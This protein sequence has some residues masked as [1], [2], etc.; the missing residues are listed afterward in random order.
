MNT[1]KKIVLTAV[2]TAVVT[3]VVSCYLTSFI[4]DNILVYLPSLN[5]D[6]NFS[7]KIKAVENMLEKKYLYDFDNQTLRENAIKSYVEGLEEPYT[8]Y[9]TEAE[10]TS[11]MQNI[12]DG[13]VGIGVTVSVND[14]NEIEVVAPFE[15]SPAYEAGIIPGD[16][17][18]SVE[19]VDYS[20]DTLT[21]AVE[22]IKNGMEGTIV[23]IT[24]V[25]NGETINLSIERRDI[26]YDS[27][28]T[29][30]LQDNIGYMR[31]TGFNMDSESGEH[32][33]SSEF[34]VQLE[35]L[36]NAGMKKLII[37]L[38]DN[39][40]GVLSEVCDI[41]DRLLPEGTITYTETKKGERKYYNSD[42]ECIN[43]PMVVLINGNSASA[44]EVL[45]GALKDY[46]KAVIVGTTSY[47][48]G[49]VQDVYPFYDGSGISLTVAKYYTPNGVCIHDIGIEP[50]ITVELS[51]EYRESYA[52]EIA[53]ENDAQLQKALEII[54][55]K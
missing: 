9:Y 51:E 47:G 4:K 22:A 55:E 3:A 36:Q 40:G 18:K 31:I 19:G 15:D 24:I 53:H 33:T 7:N 35:E 25:R 34:E 54:K 10:F 11:Y 21:E 17:I 46:E 39:P 27:V 48:K 20:G 32:S 12:R 37:D 30:M 41:A 28:K 2:I 14:N 44:S 38:R 45:T 5:E 26:S 49:I 43:I 16:I 6:K 23:N 8:H 42:A 29:E 13:Y 50:D 1:G 52:S